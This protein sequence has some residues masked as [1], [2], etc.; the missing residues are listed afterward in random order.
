[1]LIKDRTY[2]GE[3]I[4]VDGKS[5]DHVTFSDCIL[6]Y[7]G[8]PASFTNVN[9]DGCD[10]IGPWGLPAHLQKRAPYAGD[11]V[12]EPEVVLKM[13]RPAPRRWLT[14][15]R[16]FSAAPWIFLGALVVRSLTL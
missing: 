9:F 4:V 1:M 14:W 6:V 11:R 7:R 8:G 15:K 2:N 12:L 5:F 3:W 16:L 10:L 13:Q